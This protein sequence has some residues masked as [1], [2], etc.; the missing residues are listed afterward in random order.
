[1]NGEFAKHI[2]VTITSVIAIKSLLINMLILGITTYYLK[3]WVII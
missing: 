3:E 2:Q 1:M